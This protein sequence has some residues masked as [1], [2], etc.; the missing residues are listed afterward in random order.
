MV[1]YG[2]LLWGIGLGLG[3][4]FTFTNILTPEPLGARGYWSAITL[5]LT[6]SGIIVGIFAVMVANNT[7]KGKKIWLK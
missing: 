1:L 7:V 6:L 3:S 5:G 2:V 4:I